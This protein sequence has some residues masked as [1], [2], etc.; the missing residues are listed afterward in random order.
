MTATFPDISNKFMSLSPVSF[1][2]E[3][4]GGA[5]LTLFPGRCEAANP[6]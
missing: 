6:E 2:V 5:H 3:R 1:G 4:A